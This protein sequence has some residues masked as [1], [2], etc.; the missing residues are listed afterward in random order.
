M[1]RNDSPRFPAALRL[2]ASALVAGIVA[3]APAAHADPNGAPTQFNEMTVAQ[4]Q[5][6]MAAGRL[7]SV[8]LTQF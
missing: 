8:P 2:C 6:E 1:A 4:M 7:T 3:L 5:T